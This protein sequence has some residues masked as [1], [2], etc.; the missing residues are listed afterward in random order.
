MN[1]LMMVDWAAVGE[2]SAG[3]NKDM[4]FVQEVVEILRALRERTL[5]G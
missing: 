1:R 5:M 2:M 3:V 4:E